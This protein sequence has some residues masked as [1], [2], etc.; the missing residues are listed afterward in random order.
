M[1]EPTIKPNGVVNPPVAASPAARITVP[2]GPVSAAAGEAILTDALTNAF[3][4]PGTRGEQP[5]GEAGK[6]APTGTAAGAAA[7]DPENKNLAPEHNAEQEEAELAARAQANGVTVAEQSQ[8]ETDELARLEAR[9]AELG[10]TVEQVAAGEEAEATAKAGKT[11]TQEQVEGL[12]L[13]RVKNLGE[14]NAELKRQ[15]AAKPVAAGPGAGRLDN[16]ND[17]A[18]LAEISAEAR[19]GLK[20]T[21]KMI[22][23]LAYAPQAVAEKFQEMAA[24]NPAVAAR[25]RNEAGEDDFSVARMS[26]VLEESEE[27]LTAQAEA[28]P[29]RQ[30]YLETYEKSHAVALKVHPWLGD[31]EDERTIQFRN[32]ERALPGVKAAASWE[33]WVAC[34]VER[35]LELTQAAAKAA[36]ANG[37]GKFIPKVVF[38]KSAARGG[39]RPA[40]NGDQRKAALDNLRKTGS[41]KDLQVALETILGHR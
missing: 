2:T 39:N 34:A 28:V 20:F 4:E 23:Q 30:A 7:P 26:A 9:A 14:E 12:I 35:H 17:V 16:V 5:K 40:V 1:A 38:P 6:P 25:F 41:E 13:K 11:Y 31:A 15:L 10:Q 33:Y 29:V 27:N 22:R 19:E 24:N 36:P 3:L 37:K 8:A 21:G 32:I 18:K